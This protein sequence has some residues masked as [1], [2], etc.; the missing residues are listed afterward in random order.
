MAALTLTVDKRTALA[1][2]DRLIQLADNPRVLLGE[3]GECLIDST[4]QRFLE[5]L[6][7]EG[8]P[9]SPVSPAY[10]ERKR[11]GKATN[12]AGDAKTTDPSD[13]LR[14]THQLMGNLFYDVNGS[15]LVFGS[16]EPYAAA[17][18]FGIPSKNLPARPW[19]GLSAKDEAEVEALTTGYLGALFP[20][21][22]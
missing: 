11:E 2:L 8:E 14:L 1:G 22:R 7:P 19:L 3:I 10:A 20:G 12:D 6:S 9:W 15:E 5:K 16:P 17:H 13:I 21:S 18:Q 4:Q